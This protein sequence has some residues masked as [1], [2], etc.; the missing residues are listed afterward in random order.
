[1]NIKS[2]I[3]SIDFD[4]YEIYFRENKFFETVFLDNGTNSLLL[5]ANSGQILNNGIFTVSQINESFSLISKDNNI[6]FINSL[7]ENEELNYFPNRK[8]SIFDS[9]IIFYQNEEMKDYLNISLREKICRNKE[10]FPIDISLEFVDKLVAEIKSKNVNPFKN[11][12]PPSLAILE[13]WRHYKF[14]FEFYKNPVFKCYEA[15]I[16]SGLFATNYE[17]AKIEIEPTNETI[18][19][20]QLNKA[21]YI[22]ENRGTT[23]QILI[24]EFWKEYKKWKEPFELPSIT[25]NEQLFDLVKLISIRIENDDNFSVQLYFRTWDE[26]HGQYVRY[27]DKDKLEFE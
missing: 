3:K 17:T 4:R 24:E 8:I 12:L 22:E 11:Y 15:S 25:T 20:Q 10:D 6:Q 21:K 5:D 16:N 2:Y 23:R 1:M 18:S 27:I 7:V 9:A 26:E 13:Q 19:I 14:P